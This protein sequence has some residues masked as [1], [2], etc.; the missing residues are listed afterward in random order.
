MTH[1]GEVEVE[2]ETYKDL[3]TKLEETSKDYE[4]EYKPCQPLTDSQH[5]T[6]GVSVCRI[7]FYAKTYQTRSKPG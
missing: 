5:H 1:K 3:D 6:T 2:E 7:T 4:M